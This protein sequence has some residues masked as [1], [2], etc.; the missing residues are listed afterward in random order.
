[1]SGPQRTRWPVV[2]TALA[3]GIVASLHLGKVPPAVPFLRGEL[4]LD[5]VEVGFVVSTFNVL[6]ML[7]ALVVGVTADRVGRRRLIAAGLLCLAAGGA[8]GALSHGLAALLFS[9]FVEGIGFIAAV[10]ALPAVVMASASERDRPF[11]LSLWSVFMP[12]GMAL[13]LVL[14]PGILTAGGWRGLWWAIAGLSLLALLLVDRAVARVALPQRPAGTPLRVLVETVA[15]PGLLLLGLAFAAYAFQWVS[16]MVWLPT[17]LAADLG[18]APATAALL[19]ALVIVVNVPGNLSG[20]WNLRRGV[21]PGR[22]IA[23]GSAGMALAALGIFSHAVPDVARYGL[24]LVF[25]FTAGMI[26][27]SLFA[28]APGH[29]PSPG[30]MGAANGILMQGSA[31]GQFPGPPVIAAAVAAA[32]GDWGG[33]RWPLLAA[34]VLTVAAGVG[35]AR[36]ARRRAV[37]PAE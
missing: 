14:A 19:T 8:V 12:A 28:G 26:P 6:G 35:A 30:H 20:G 1:M 27:S 31:L 29:A 18:A 10:V 7:L 17:F 16:L 25:S 9:R 15:R 36:L 37:A 34:A 33:A 32:G 13:A 22:L 24:C 4:G 5:L 2:L 3:G 21:A 11:A 23:A